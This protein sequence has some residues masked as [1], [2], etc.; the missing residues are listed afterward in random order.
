[1]AVL[2]GM[3]TIQHS[4]RST[5]LSVKLCVVYLT[6]KTKFALLSSCRYC[7]DRARNLTGPAL[8]NVLRML[9]ISSK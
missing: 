7:A 1:M 3:S 6:K 5:R 9:Q 2:C 8:D 4:T